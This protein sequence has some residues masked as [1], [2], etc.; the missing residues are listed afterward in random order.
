MTPL[1]RMGGG[2]GGWAHRARSG[3]NSHSLF[4]KLGDSENP[5]F[6]QCTRAYARANDARN[7]AKYGCKMEKQGITL[8]RFTRPEETTD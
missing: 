7:Y 1:K 8:N 4:G 5:P 3:E 6:Y 2:G